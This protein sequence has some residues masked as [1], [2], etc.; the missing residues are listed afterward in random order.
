MHL[1]DLKAMLGQKMRDQAGELLIVF[2]QQYFAKT[3]VIHNDRLLPLSEVAGI[4]AP[5]GD[6]TVMTDS[7]NRPQGPVFSDVSYS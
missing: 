6:S 1:P 7:K 2:Y 3:Q 5:I 4:M